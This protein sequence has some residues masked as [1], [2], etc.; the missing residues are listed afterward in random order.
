MAAPEQAGVVIEHPNR[1]TD[2]SRITRFAVCALLLASAALI[3]VV[4]IGGW[5][6]LQGMRAVGIAWIL[7]YLGF[8]WY[9]ARWNRGV[10]PVIAALCVIMAIFA[11]LAV[12]SWFDRTASGYAQPTLDANVLGALTAIIVGLQVLLALVAAQGFTQAWNVEVERPVGSPVSAD[13]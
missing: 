10:L 5:D 9:V 7:A 12:P 6:A 1:E 11:L 8:A 4:L 3:A 13:G 2:A